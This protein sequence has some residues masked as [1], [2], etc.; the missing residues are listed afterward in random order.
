MTLSTTNAHAPARSKVKLLII[1]GK[2]AVTAACFWYLSWQIDVSAVSSSVRLFDVRWAT[3]AILLAMLQ[4]PLVAV[5]WR[6]ILEALDAVNRRI[7]NASIV[8][9]TAIG[10]FFAQVLPSMMG[11]GI[12]AWLLVRLGCDW[13]RALTSV[14][15]DRAV[16]VGLL[17]AFGFIILLL[18]SGLSAL[19]GYRDLVLMIYG[20]L[21]LAGAV[22]LLLLPPLIAFLNRMPYL[23]W[24]A[25]LA[26]DVRCV[27]L[28]RQR[29]AIVLSAAA[30]IHSF[31][32]LIIWS[33]A[34]AQGW[35]LP[36]LDAAVLFVIMIGV[37]VV[38]VSINGWGLRELAVVALLGRQGIAPEQALVFSVCFGFV[39]ALG[40]LPGALAWVLYS[41]VPAK[42]SM[43]CRG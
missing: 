11:E 15:I 17:V 33:L 13:R 18:P 29:L 27:V 2:L 39:L 5:R 31:S 3:L 35:L 25:G 43:E 22:G 24:V 40:S 8:A 42:A 14:V 12:R 19:G 41:A 34:R 6:S 26:A 36:S 10:L 9:I 21:L 1:A 23:R 37:A 20:M 28:S 4:I 7:T 38:P 30:V 32:I 16:G